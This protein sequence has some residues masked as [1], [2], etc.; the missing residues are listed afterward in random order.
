MNRA[1]HDA[2]VAVPI[3]VGDVVASVLDLLVIGV[4]VVDAELRVRWLNRIARDVL[5]PT[6]GMWIGEGERLTVEDGVLGD[7]LARAVTRAL[8]ECERRVSPR[9]RCGCA[10]CSV[11][12]Q[13]PGSL[14][15]TRLPFSDPTALI[16][17]TAPATSQSRAPATLASL[18]K[19]TRAEAGIAIDV[20][21][22]ATISE[23][24]NRRRITWH[25][26]RTHVKHVFAKA[27]VS[28]RTGLL[29]AF[30]SGPAGLARLIRTDVPGHSETL[31]SH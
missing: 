23:I 20:L 16:L 17:L 24:A 7:E 3:A 15:V 11:P 13:L 4:V 21:A 27:G 25:T 1:Q 6:G 22:G 9:P 2:S 12:D 8:H 30:L 18:Y 5:L 29:R 19:L 28:G 31:G 14:F 10:A 26:T